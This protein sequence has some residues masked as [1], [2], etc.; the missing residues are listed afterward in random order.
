MRND[1]SGILLAAV[2][3]VALWLVLVIVGLPNIIAGLMAL[4]VLA[5]LLR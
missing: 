1:L 4:V 3:A 5:V 2:F